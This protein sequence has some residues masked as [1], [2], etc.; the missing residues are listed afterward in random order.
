[1]DIWIP[2]SQ[3]LKS[4]HGA[5]GAKACNSTYLPDMTLTLNEMKS[6]FPNC[7]LSP[8]KWRS[9]DERVDAFTAQEDF[10]QSQKVKLNAEIGKIHRNKNFS[11]EDKLKK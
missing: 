9:H 4:K 2:I 11:D 6:P 5:A 10:R 7:D 1:V 8:D 3:D